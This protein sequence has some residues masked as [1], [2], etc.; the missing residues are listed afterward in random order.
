[1]NKFA[2]D[3]TVRVKEDAPNSLRRGQKA[4]VTMVFLPDDRSG[5]YFNRF[6]PGVLY[7][8]EYEDGE[9]ADIHEDFL[10][11]DSPSVRS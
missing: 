10:E 2:F 4:S 1:M 11:I 5:S 8:V 3:D 6:S 9:S 7:S